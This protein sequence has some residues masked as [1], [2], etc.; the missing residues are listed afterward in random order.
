MDKHLFYSESLAQKAKHEMVQEN[1][2][3]NKN[4]ESAKFPLMTIEM[5]EVKPDKVVPGDV[6]KIPYNGRFID[7]N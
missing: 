4:I 5:P 1:I 7:V 6:L 2:E 3:L